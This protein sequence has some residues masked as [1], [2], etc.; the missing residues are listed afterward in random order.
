MRPLVAHCHRGLGELYRRADKREEARAHLATA[1]TMYREMGM[2]VWL[3][4]AE[5][6]LEPAHE[7]SP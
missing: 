1:S 6:A 4:K 2:S 5:A 7:I 3:E